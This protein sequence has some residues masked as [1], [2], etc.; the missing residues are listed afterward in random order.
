MDL[1][2]EEIAVVV[3]GAKR[4]HYLA[5]ARIPPAVTTR[6]G[7]LLVIALSLPAF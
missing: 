7:V 2:N 3:S 5:Q 4:R 1:V 6:R